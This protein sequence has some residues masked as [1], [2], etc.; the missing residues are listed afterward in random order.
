[1]T[2]PTAREAADDGIQGVLKYP[3]AE[4]GHYGAKISFKV[5]QIDGPQL[6]GV[7]SVGELL[8]KVGKS[9]VEVV[10][11]GTEEE[12]TETTSSGSDDGTGTLAKGRD[13]TIDGKGISIF[14]PVAFNT[15]DT[16][17][18]DSPSIGV[19]GASLAN[20][21]DNASGTLGGALGGAVKDLL[22]TFNTGG[23]TDLARLG[24]ARLARM[25]PSEIGDGMAA[26]L[27]VTVDP[28]IRTLFR[29][30]AVRNFQFQF[31][32]IAKSAKEAEE[33]KKIIKRFRFY[34]YPESIVV[35]TENPIS[36][37]FKYPNPFNINI[38]YETDKGESYRLGPKIKDCYLTSVT[39]NYNPTNMSF[40]SDGN[41]VEIDMSLSFTEGTTLNKKDII[42]DF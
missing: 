24:V 31:K 27:R 33:V 14:L 18:Y 34:A 12:K 7:T 37:G 6:K 28:N 11:T 41:P 22:S 36:V 23:S 40:H 38:T 25:G 13:R 29:G 42:E 39:T 5:K 8:R 2:E 17:T 3:Y 35:G 15:T 10:T 4:D 32:F 21:L 1:M 19:S 9:V 30:V 20:S 26:S 16:L